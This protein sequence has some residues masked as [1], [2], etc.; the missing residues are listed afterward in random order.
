MLSFMDVATLALAPRRIVVADDGF[1]DRVEAVLTSPGDW[2]PT[3]S[4]AEMWPSFAVEVLSHG[5]LS[6]AFTPET[7]ITGW[8]GA[9]AIIDLLEP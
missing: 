1:M 7:G 9:A 5:T 3:D 6:S 4:P 2:A 8:L